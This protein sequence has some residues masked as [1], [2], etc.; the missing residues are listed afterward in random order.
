MGNKD[1][2]LQIPKCV[3]LHR[4]LPYD[5]R[6][7]LMGNGGIEVN[8]DI[9]FRKAALWSGSAVRNSSTY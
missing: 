4:R 8:C 9:S 3:S 2:Q 1:S 7:R 6:S 5:L